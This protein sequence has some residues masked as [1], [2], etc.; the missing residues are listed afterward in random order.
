MQHIQIYSNEAKRRNKLQRQKLASYARQVPWIRKMLDGG[1]KR[2]NENVWSNALWTSYRTSN[3]TCFEE[4]FC[5]ANQIAE[6]D[7][8]TNY[9]QQHCNQQWTGIFYPYGAWCR[10]YF[11]EWIHIR[12]GNICL[13][14]V[15]EILKY[16]EK[17]IREP[18]PLCV[19]NGEY[20]WIN[21]LRFCSF[22]FVLCEYGWAGLHPPGFHQR[23]NGRQFVYAKFN[24]RGRTRKHLKLSSIS[25]S[26]I[27]ALFHVR[28]TNNTHNLRASNSAREFLFSWPFL[29]EF[30]TE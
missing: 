29:F 27:Q 13:F 19:Y 7:T 15:S 11:V 18:L 22:L 14:D 24:T 12:S 26:C 5:A 9:T 20:F 30:Q 17:R 16:A 2:K 3:K 6:A 4:I 28:S 10:I 1:T 21:L 25:S 23:V 8:D